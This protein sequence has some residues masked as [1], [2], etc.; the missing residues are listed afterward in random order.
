LGKQAIKNNSA[1][2]IFN[3]IGIIVALVDADWLVSLNEKLTSY[4]DY[5]NRAV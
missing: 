5:A 1:G 2:G 4:K 3:G